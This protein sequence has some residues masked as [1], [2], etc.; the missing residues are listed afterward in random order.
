MQ[1]EDQPAPSCPT[2]PKTGPSE[3]GTDGKDSDL[4]EPL[5]LKLAVAFF[6]RGL[7]DTSEDEGNRM[8]PEPAVLE[9]SQWV[10]WKAKRCKTLERWTE[11]LTVPGIEDCR[12]LAREVWASFGLRQWMWELGVREA[13][14]QAPPVPPC[15]CRWRFMLPAESIYACR[16][17][18]E[19][20]REK[21]VAYARAL[22]HWAEENNPPAGGEPQ[23]LA[24]SVIELR[25]EVKWC[26][27]FTDEEVFWEVAL[28][29]KEEDESL[30]TL[31]TDIPEVPCV[32]EPTPER[33]GPK[34]LGWEKV[35]HPSW[36]VVAAGEIPPPSK[37][38]RPKGG[39]SQLPQMIPIQHP[40][41][42]PKT[43]TPPKPSSLVQALALMQ[44]STLPHCFVGVTACLWTAELV[45]VALELPLGTMPFGVVAA[46]RISTLSTSCIVRD[47]ATGMT[48]M[49][50][51]TTSI[52]RV[53]LRGP[54]SEASSLGP[55]IKAMTGWE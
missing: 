4:E 14:L 19:I 44:L 35:L 34:F 28:P 45:E 25:E 13:T 10:P 40:V 39:S 36:P 16:D 54:D 1:F 15:L 11:L 24:E 30:K 49:D 41:S 55:M 22:Q 5:E 33:R 21:V 53:A 27:S 29:K 46:P 31:S 50:T 8:P 38:L 3:E 17:I 43:P 26:L 52:G 32:L 37:T 12:K 48:Y 47:K 6:L 7:P 9:F 23:L 42:P 18:R 2:D 20:P 51:V